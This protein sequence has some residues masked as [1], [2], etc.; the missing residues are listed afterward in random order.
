MDAGSDPTRLDPGK[1]LR[2]KGGNGDKQG[3]GGRAI[4]MERVQ[5]AGRAAAAGATHMLL[6]PVPAALQQMPSHNLN[7]LGLQELHG[8]SRRQPAPLPVHFGP[9]VESNIAWMAAHCFGASFADWPVHTAAASS[10][11][12]TAGGPAAAGGASSSSSSAS[13][14]L[15]I[16]TSLGSSQPFMVRDRP[17]AVAQRI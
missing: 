15:A 9:P 3:G 14:R 10:P 17:F 13:I 6:I 5:G 16:S 4:S 2:H 8:S 1:E 11:V 12:I 7:T